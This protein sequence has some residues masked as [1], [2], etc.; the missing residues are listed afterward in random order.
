M[1]RMTCFRVTRT[2]RV[3]DVA[4]AGADKAQL[5]E[6]L[7]QLRAESEAAVA[8]SEDAVDAAVA[9]KEAALAKASA[10]LAGQAAA[11]ADK[12]AALERVRVLEARLLSADLQAAGTTTMMATTASSAIVPHQLGGP[13]GVPQPAAAPCASVL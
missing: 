11:M 12:E 6:L 7:R 3:R 5:E 4:A 10:A 8:E 1:M 13:L 2:I 9:D